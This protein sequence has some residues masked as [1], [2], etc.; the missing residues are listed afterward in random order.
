[1]DNTVCKKIDTVVFDFDGTVMN[2]NNVIFKSWQHTFNRIRGRDGDIEYIRATLGEPLEYSMRKTFP[3][4][5]LEESIRIYRD[6]HRDRFPDM[7]ELFPGIEELLAA[8]K[9]GGYRTGLAT[10]RLRQTTYQGLGKYDLFRFFDE[11]ITVEDV[12]RAK[13]DPEMLL[14]M[15]DRLHSEPETSVMVGDT[16]LDIGCANNAGVTSVLVGWSEA[17]AGKTRED[18]TG[19]EVPDHIVGSPAELSEIVG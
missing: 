1:M 18:F 7:I 17:L 10:S 12:S 13:P 2:T 6:Y 9:A 5:P 15:L 11:V 4:V 16:K 14:T 19:N 8:L 3:E